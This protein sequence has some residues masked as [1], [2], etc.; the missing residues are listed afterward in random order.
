MIGAQGETLLPV[1]IQINVP[2]VPAS[3]VVFASPHSGRRY[4]VDMLRRAV[5]DAHLLRSSEDAFVDILLADAP[6][7]GAPLVTSEVPRAYVDFNRGADELD[8]ALIQ[9]APRA[10]LN[11]R[12]ASGLGVIAR[13]VANGRSIYRGKIPLAEAEARLARYWHPYHDGLWTLLQRQQARFG[14]VL[15][16]D[17]HSMPSEALSGFALRGAQR[18]DVVLGDRWGSSCGADVLDRVE[19][20]LTDAGLRVAR[21]TPFSGAYILQRY[22]Q[23]SQG[24]HAVQIEIDR[25][26]YLDEAKVT[27]GANFESFRAV[28]RTVVRGLATID[29]G[30]RAS[31]LAA[32]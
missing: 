30:E 31:D 17:M 26:L 27:P 4:P 6:D 18:P 23:P 9:G 16:C 15:L 21:N 11:P 19:A 8:P 14:Q 25:G 24:R 12:V 13:V 10:G 22:G 28:M 3:P 1:A 2:P 7:F 5:I 29:L 20:V 32:E